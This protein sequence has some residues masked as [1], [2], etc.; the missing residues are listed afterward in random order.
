MPIRNSFHGRCQ[1]GTLV[2]P[3]TGYVIGRRIWCADCSGEALGA[4][5]Q[6]EREDVERYERY[7]DRPIYGFDDV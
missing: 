1:C 7:G 6:E 4:R 5:E 2:K 3:Q